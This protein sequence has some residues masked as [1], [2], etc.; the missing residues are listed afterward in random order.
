[1]P[2]K[3]TL[4]GRRVLGHLPVWAENEK[5]HIKAE[6]G[7]E[8]SIRS[9][10]LADF[11]VRLAEDPST[12]ILDD[13]GVTRSLTEAECGVSLEALAHQGL[14]EEIDGQWRMTQLGFEALTAHEEPESNAPSEVVVPLNPAIAQSEALGS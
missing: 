13:H 11:T 14:A 3:L 6:G 1:M 8:V 9:Y 4:L 7:P 12:F 5:A 10:S 2:P